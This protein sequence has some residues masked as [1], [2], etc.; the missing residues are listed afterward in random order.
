[1]GS[2]YVEFIELKKSVDSACLFRLR[3]KGPT[4]LNLPPPLSEKVRNFFLLRMASF[5]CLLLVISPSW[6]LPR[7]DSFLALSKEVF[8]T[9]NELNT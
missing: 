1:M 7:A 8:N 3:Q 6:R 2:K 4:N 5:T 9:G